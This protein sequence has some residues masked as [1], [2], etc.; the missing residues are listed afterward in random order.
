MREKTKIAEQVNENDDIP[1]L[2]ISSS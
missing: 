1:V 2:D